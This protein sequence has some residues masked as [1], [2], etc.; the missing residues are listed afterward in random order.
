MLETKAL[1]PEV[2][3]LFQLI[4]SQADDYSKA[5]ENLNQ[6]IS[7][8][9]NTIESL[10][11]YKDYFTKEFTQLSK[12]TK[13]DVN[14]ILKELEYKLDRVTLIHD[15][16]ENIY[17]FKYSLFQLS[18]K[19]KK[20]YN[21]ADTIIEAFKSKSEA[22]LESTLT[23]LKF[24]LEKEI[25]YVSHRYEARIDLKVK[26]LE[27]Q[28]LNYDQKFISIVD[29]QNKEFKSIKDDVDSLRY[30]VNKLFHSEDA[31]ETKHEL[32]NIQFLQLQEQFDEKI[33][34]LNKV[35]K[36]SR[37]E[38]MKGITDSIPI[39]KFNAEL[40]SLKAISI[41]THSEIEIALKKL[42]I[43]QGIAI[44]SLIVSIIAITVGFAM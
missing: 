11:N 44:G 43:A 32:K 5:F 31:K 12:D 9:N 7:E 41:N 40:S 21:S 27:S 15:N 23:Y 4:T 14:A 36:Q 3:E 22:D 28:L 42:G 34:N 10:N 24:K 18:E 39:D 30:K 25:E 6:K 35:I 29:Y 8:F 16:L 38:S 17:A 37:D 33:E 20:Q 13:L 19:L 2:K 1:S 26:R